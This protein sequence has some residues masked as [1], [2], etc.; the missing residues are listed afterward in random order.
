MAE[1]PERTKMIIFAEE[2]RNL[3]VNLIPSYMGKP[4]DKRDDEIKNDGTPV[5]NLDLYI[6]EKLQE[7]ISKHFPGEITI[8][9]EDK[10]SLEE[11]LR[12]MNQR[13]CQWTIDGLD[14]TGNRSMNT[15]SY[16][17][18]VSRRQGNIILFAA[19]FRPVDEVLRGNGFSYAKHGEGAWQW[20]YE[21][22]EYHQMFTAKHGELKRLTVMLEGSSKKLFQPPISTV[23]LEITTR[24]SF[25]N[26][27][28][29]TTVAMGKASALV[30]VENKPWDNW[31]A[32]CLIKEA[33]GVV[34]D[35]RGNSFAPENCENMIAAAN[36]EDHVV[37]LEIINR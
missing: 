17:A 5:G 2:L 11:M 29:A 13:K 10:K 15:N 18:M 25:S 20:C 36:R 4:H 21:C 16:G 23:G 35:W 14:G 7:L 8:G 31:P 1:W 12:L 32:A 30:T 3:F 27:V 24:L 19:I 28:A 26:C 9:E 22:N 37:I 33:G 6:M 34:T